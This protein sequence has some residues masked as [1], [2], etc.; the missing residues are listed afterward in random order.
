MNLKKINQKKIGAN[1]FY[2]V[3]KKPPHGCVPVG[4]RN[5]ATP[6]RDFIFTFLAMEWQ[7]S[8]T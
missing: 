8:G 2:F 7:L 1:H 6:E 3:G 5:Q 4:H